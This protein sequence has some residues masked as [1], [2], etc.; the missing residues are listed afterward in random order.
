MLNKYAIALYKKGMVLCNR[1]KKNFKYYSS[2]YCLECRK[3]IKSKHIPPK[4]ELNKLI[5]EKSFV[6]IGNMF[7]V[8]DNAVRRW[9]EKYGLPSKRKDIINEVS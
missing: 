6:E 1:C 7:N 3:E 5:H 2:I 4:E 8:S 9:C